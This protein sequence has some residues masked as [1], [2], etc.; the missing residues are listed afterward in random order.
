MKKSNKLASESVITQ[1]N[2]DFSDN[3]KRPNDKNSRYCTRCTRALKACL[4]DYIRQVSH[5]APLH[6]LQH[7]SEA[8]HPKGTAA[9]LAASLTQARIH[10]GEDFAGAQWLNALLADPKMHCYLLWPDEQAL[11]LDLVRER[12][13]QND[14]GGKVCFILLDGT[15]RKAY[16]MLHSNPALLRL[17]RIKLG[18][19]PG[20]YSIRKKPFP[21]A[22]STLEA[23]YH[24]L[25]QWEGEPERFA[26]LM[27][28]FTH[29]NQ[30][31]HDFA[32]GRRV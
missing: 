12:I 6:I 14:E 15:W 22:L 23:G 17:P 30:Q 20:Q 2:P 8:G 19:I 10:V 11:G 5:L 9:L 4:C 32:Q 25:S 1:S 26:P 29:L 13:V 16:R 28:L 18:A 3:M 21:E 7:P 24:L 31:W 27:T